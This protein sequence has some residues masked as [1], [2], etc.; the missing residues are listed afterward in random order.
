MGLPGREV[1]ADRIAQR[2]DRGV[3][4]GAQAATAAPD[5]LALFRPLF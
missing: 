4:L 2:I 1:K 5:G 3:N